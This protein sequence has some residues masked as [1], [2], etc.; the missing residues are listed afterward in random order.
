MPYHRLDPSAHHLQ[1]GTSLNSPMIQSPHTAHFDHL[2]GLAIVGV[3]VHHV[4]VHTGMGIPYL[5]SLG[6]LL[7]VQLFFVL[8]GYLIADSAARHPLGSYAWHRAL[9]IF[10]AYWVAYLFVGFVG[11]RIAWAQVLADPAPFLLNL[12]NLQQ[13]DPVALIDFDALSVSWTLTI[14]VLWYLLAPLVVW[15]GR[16]RPWTV[17]LILFAISASWTWLAR[18]GELDFLFVQRFSE[19]Q[20]VHAPR[21]MQ[22]FLHAAFPAQVVHFGWGALLYFYRDR[23]ASVPGWLPWAVAITLLALLPLC[24]GR[25]PFDH[26]ISGFAMAAFLLAVLKLPAFN[27]APLGWTGKVS[28]PIYLLHFP[29]IVY[30]NHKLAHLGAANLLVIGLLIAGC[31]TVMHYGVERPGMA[32]ARRLTRPKAT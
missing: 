29:I 15:L 11:Q 23:L 12:A 20:H 18:A 27:I 2:R 19:V 22:I 28:Y 7:G 8:S 21:Q 16:K 4:H 1:P 5:N 6:G 31:A 13:L 32:L 25:T 3:L 17:L 30:C 14:E 10:P 9:R 26:L 24:I